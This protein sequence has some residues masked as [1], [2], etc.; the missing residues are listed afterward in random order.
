MPE[1]Y[2]IK[3]LGGRYLACGPGLRMVWTEDVTKAYVY[4]D[5]ATADR[6]ARIHDADYEA[7]TTAAKH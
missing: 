1:Q 7:V 6:L 2:R 4:H 3:H 5:A